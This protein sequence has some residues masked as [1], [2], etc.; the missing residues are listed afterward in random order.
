[1]TDHST[2]LFHTI[3]RLRDVLEA[4]KFEK[5]SHSSDTFR[6][7]VIL[8]SEL[9]RLNSRVQGCL[10]NSRDFSQY[11]KSCTDLTLLELNCLITEV[12]YIN[13][14]I[15]NLLNFDEI[16]EEIEHSSYERYLQNASSELKAENSNQNLLRLNIK[17]YELLQRKGLLKEA[18]KRRANIGELESSI[19]AMENIVSTISPKLDAVLEA[20]SPLHAILGDEK[21]RYLVNIDVFKNLARFVGVNF[22]TTSRALPPGNRLQRGA[23]NMF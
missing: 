11:Q 2:S 20:A 17:R 14:D 18:A 8:L 7:I 16:P 4:S 10:R 9:R 22:L 15:D 1:M 5:I 21:V 6:E 12:S 3:N 13:Y 19:T 23:Q